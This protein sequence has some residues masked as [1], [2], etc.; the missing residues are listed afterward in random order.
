MLNRKDDS[1]R[2]Y[3]SILKK[4]MVRV[5]ALVIVLLVVVNLSSCGSN[6]YTGEGVVA[7]E[8]GNETGGIGS[9]DNSSDSQTSVPEGLIP[10]NGGP[11]QQTVTV[12]A[13]AN[14]TPIS[15]KLKSSDDDL[16]ENVD[17]KDLPFEV[18]IA[19]YLDDKKIDAEKLAGATG[20]LRIRFDYV[21]K[22]STEDSMIPL[23]FISMLSLP[24]DRFFNVEVD[25]GGVTTISGNKLVY[26]YAMPGIKEALK[27]EEAM[28]KLKSIGDDLL[29]SDEKE[30][31]KK[32][33]KED[34]FRD[35]VEISAYVVDCKIDFTATMVSNGML[36]DMKNSEIDDI[37]EVI[38]GFD[39]FTSTGNEL[40][41]GAAALRRGAV[42]FGSGLREYINGVGSLGEGAKGISD[43]AS[44]LSEGAAGL[45]AGAAELSSGA[46][47]VYGGI[48]QLASG[49]AAL[50]QSIPD[51]EGLEQLK[52]SVSAL[53]SAASSLSTGASGLATGASELSSGAS[54]LSEGAKELSEGAIQL[55]QG[56]ETLSSAGSELSNGYSGLESGANALEDGMIELN[57]KMFAKLGSLSEGE[58]PETI[59]L[60][61]AMKQADEGFTAWKTF[62]GE[63]GSIMFILETEEI[64]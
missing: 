51:M 12:K 23:T 61:R 64:K 14:G 22:A 50:E 8:E 40:V 45:S 30:E 13:Q 47:Q 43:G 57:N 29:D 28:D 42:S 37:E 3:K 6:N 26:G 34:I 31:E 17:I 9:D 11:V 19:Y 4:L 59:Q 62:D 46:E 20:N 48:S 16:E 21:N 15:A 60:L 49:L 33:K 63:E 39:D 56:A 7:V 53:S 41:D 35:Y 2:M 52:E 27:L 44:G 10:G 25:N 1:G 5:I 58:I 36:K 18:K 24:D 32:E 55:S 38:D 54:Q